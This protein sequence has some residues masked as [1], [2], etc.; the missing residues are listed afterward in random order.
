MGITKTSMTEMD[1]TACDEF[2]AIEFLASQT[3]QTALQWQ[4][5]SSRRFPRK[6]HDD[7]DKPLGWC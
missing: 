1:A 4:L 2:N 6:G 3:G 5:L 7:H